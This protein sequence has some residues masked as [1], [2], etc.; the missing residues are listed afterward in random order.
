MP[1]HS[2]S[3][4]EPGP[5]CRHCRKRLI[6]NYKLKTVKETVW[7]PWV[8]DPNESPDARWVVEFDAQG[9]WRR[10]DHVESVIKKVAT[11]TY[12]VDGVGLFCSHRC[13]F[14]WAVIEVKHLENMA[15]KKQ[16]MNGQPTR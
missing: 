9:R 2:A 1:T 12:G 8:T 7:G 15:R 5:H 13:G 4:P 16:A 14:N 6:A 3:K 10:R 11:G